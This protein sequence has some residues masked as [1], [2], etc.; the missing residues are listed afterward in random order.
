[1]SPKT[2]IKKKWRDYFLNTIC[3]FILP[4]PNKLKHVIFKSSK[5]Q[6]LIY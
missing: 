4:K 1:M 2:S 6:T 3:L 5:Q